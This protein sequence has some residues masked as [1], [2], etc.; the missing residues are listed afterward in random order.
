MMTDAVVSPRRLR[1]RWARLNAVQGSLR[2]QQ[3]RFQGQLEEIDRYLSTFDGVTQALDSLTEALFEQTLTL[4]EEKLTIALQEV[5][6]EPIRLKTE[7]S[8][9]RNTLNIDFYIDR[10]GYREDIMKGQG[11]SVANILSVGL[12]ILA[13]TRLDPASHRRFLVLDEQDC[14][15]RPD[16][17]PRLVKIVQQAGNELGFQVLMISHHNVEAFVEYADSVYE[18]IPDSDGVRCIARKAAEEEGP[19]SS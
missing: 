15:L 12:R 19:C 5:L 17:V 13:L 14:W 9:C 11:G 7:R 10:R 2:T 6:E 16:L 3:K 8:L 1:E 4:L 18:L